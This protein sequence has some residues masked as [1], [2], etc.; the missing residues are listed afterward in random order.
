VF[1]RVNT[2]G[3][4]V[5]GAGAH[6]TSENAALGDTGDGS[7]EAAPSMVSHV[8]GELNALSKTTALPGF[9]WV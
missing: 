3:G 2:P 4:G 8:V 5:E 1:T 6:V 9:G 7:L